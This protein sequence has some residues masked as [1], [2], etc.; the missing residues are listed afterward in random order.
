[1]VKQKDVY[2]GIMA[3]GV[4][5]LLYFLYFKFSGSEPTLEKVTNPNAN[6]NKPITQPLVVDGG[7]GGKVGGYFTQI[8]PDTVPMPTQQGHTTE[9]NNQSGGKV[10]IQ[11]VIPYVD[12]SNNV[13][14]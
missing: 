1:M 4:I 9:G 10:P 13:I 2:Y 12:N 6:L 8:F 7:G 11:I 3:V 5:A 14:L